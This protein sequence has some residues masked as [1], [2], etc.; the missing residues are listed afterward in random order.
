MKDSGPGPVQ[1]GWRSGGFLEAV[2]PEGRVDGLGW[3]WEEAS[4][5]VTRW[6]VGMTGRRKLS[7]AET[8][9]EGRSWPGSPRS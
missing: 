7:E 3:P 5:P 2:S 4:G 8:S 9:V 6:S 1:V